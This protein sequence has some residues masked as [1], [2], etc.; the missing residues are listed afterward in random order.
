M[1]AGRAAD[2]VRAYDRAIA[3]RPDY[4]DPHFNRGT[5]LLGLQRFQEA[6]ASF[7]QAI[8]LSPRLA[9]AHY[10]RGVTLEA[11][12]RPRDALGSYRTVLD[13]EP[14]HVQA[15]FNL[16]CLYLADKQYDEALACMDAVI[17]QAP[18]VARAHGNRGVALLRTRRPREAVAAFDQALTLEPRSAETLNNRGNAYLLLK[19]YDKAFEDL[20]CVLQQRPDLPHTRQLMGT[21]LGQRKQHDA[22]RE[23]FLLAYQRAPEFPLLLGQVVQAKSTVC[24]WSQWESYVTKMTQEL[25]EGRA[26]AAPFAVLGVIDAPDAQLAAAR[27]CVCE[28]HPFRP[29]LGPIR[30]VRRNG[31]I[32]VGYYSADFHN[33]ATALLAAE[34]FELHDRERFEWFAFS[35]G[36]DTQDAMR[37]RLE[38][39][40]DHFLD[41]KDC[42]N[43]EIARRSRELGIDIAV[44]LKGFTEDERF[45]IFSYRCAPVQV[46]YLGYPGT[47]GADYMDYVLADKVVLP[48]ESQPYFS[49]KAV[50][51]PHSYQPNDS[52]RHI[53]ERVFTREEVGLHEPAFVYCCFNNNYKIQPSTFDGWMRILQ[54]VEGS[55]LWLLE[56]NPSVVKNLRREAQARGVAPERLVFAPRMEL[57]EHLARHRLADLFLDTLPCNAHTTA[58]DALWTGLPVLTCLGQSF[59]SR[60]AA[61]LLHAVGMPELVTDN[62]ADYEALAIALARNPAQLQAVRDKLRANLPSAPLFDAALLARHIEQAYMAMHERAVQGL[63]PE[64]IEV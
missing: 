22:A 12:Q 61:S 27:A 2:A 58:S 39:A 21:L 14:G 36:P 16:G 5:A 52:Q 34:L 47:T 30:A 35:I 46:S 26:A 10:N 29:D 60:V 3:L 17:A 63:P 57:S 54:A 51:L 4:L 8:A 64:V 28:E 49:E 50:Y 62:Q 6:L 20:S 32:R 43:L 53:S 40:F 19:D 1:Q 41:V 15:R 44:D 45:G 18:Q 7:D 56:D 31:K 37:Q 59:A 23:Q 11:L 9:V 55:V 33:H 48:P 13:I 38:K 25:R 24:D 42:S